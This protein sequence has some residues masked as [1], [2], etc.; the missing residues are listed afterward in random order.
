MMHAFI[1]ALLTCRCSVHRLRNRWR[2][3]R[4]RLADARAEIGSAAPPRTLST[5]RRP[6]SL[7]STAPR[8]HRGHAR[9]R[10]TGGT[11]RGVRPPERKPQTIQRSLKVVFGAA[12][13]DPDAAGVSAAFAVGDDFIAAE[14]RRRE[15]IRS[16]QPPRWP[17]SNVASSFERRVHRAE[18]GGRM[19]IGSEPIVNINIFGT[20]L[21]LLC[22]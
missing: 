13:V 1:T 9:A 6:P 2:F 12:G 16:T 22:W 3:S 4:R 7:Q 10:R 20:K 21:L 8:R 5:C 18:E 14:T 17:T 15:R 19:R 11:V